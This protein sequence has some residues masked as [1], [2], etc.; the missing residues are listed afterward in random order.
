MSS[1]PEVS[2]QEAEAL[3]NQI[4]N[5][6]DTNNDKSISLH[7]FQSFISKDLDILK[8]LLSYG[9]ISKEDLRPDYGGNTDVPETDSDLENE[10]NKA[11]IDRDERV[12]MIKEG[13]EHVF[14]FQ[15]QYAEFYEK[16][17]VSTKSMQWKKTIL[18]PVFQDKNKCQDQLPQAS[19]EMEFIYGFRCSDTRQNIR[20]N[21][22]NEIVYHNG[23]VG[24]VYDLKGNQ[25][26][27][28]DHTDDI[29]CMD[30]N[31]NLVATG[32]IGL[33]PLLCIW[34]S[35][36]M[37]TKVTFKGVLKNGIGQ[38]A[39]SYDYRRVAA[40]SLEKNKCIVVY[41]VEKAINSKL[42][43]SLKLQEDGLICQTTLYQPVVFDLKFDKTGKG[44]IAACLNE[45]LFMQIEGQQLKIVKGVWSQQNSPQ[46]SLCISFIETSVITGMFKGQLLVWKNSKLS[47]QHP[48]HSGPVMSMY[49]RDQNS[50]IIT[51]GKDGIVIV[52]DN[53]LKKLNRIDLKETKVY[54]SKITAVA[55]D[56]KMENLI[57]GT[58]SSEIIEVLKKTQTKVIMSGHWDGKLYGLTVHPKTQFIYTVGEDNLLAQWDLKKHVL[59]QS[60]KLQFPARCIELCNNQKH[61]AIGC[62][63][64]NVLIVDPKSLVVM[65]SFK[66]NNDSV[67]CLKFSLDCEYL[68]VAYGQ[69]SCEIYAYNCKNTF[70]Q[71]VK[72]K[73]SQ[74]PVTHIDFAKEKKIIQCCNQG[75]QLLFF[76]LV[77]LNSHQKPGKQ[78]REKDYAILKNIKWETNTC[79]YGYDIQGIW[80]PCSNGQDIN[81]VDLSNKY[82][83]LIAGDDFSNVKIFQYPCDFQY[84][85]FIKYSGHS[86]HI[87]KVRFAYEDQYVVSIGGFDKT[88]IQWKYNHEQNK[89]ELPENIEKKNNYNDDKKEN[90]VN[91]KNNI[92]IP[93]QYEGQ[94]SNCVPSAY[95]NID[96]QKLN[97]I[98]CQ[99]IQLSHVFGVR[100]KH[101]NEICKNMIK[102]AVGEKIVYTTAGVCIINDINKQQYFVKHTNDIISLAVHPKGNIAATGS[103]SNKSKT[104]EIYIWEIE[105][106][107]IISQ[108]NDFHIN[109]VSHIEFSPDGTF[110]LT[111]G[112][113]QNYSI[114]IYD[115]Q[116]SRMV[117][118]Q[119]TDIFNVTGISWKNNMEF[120]SC[121]LAH[122][123]F[124]KIQGRNLSFKSGSEIEIFQQQM[125]VTYTITGKCISGSS[126]GCLFLWNENIL[127]NKI[128][129]H[130]KK[131]NCLIS[132]GNESIFSGGD[133]GKIMKWKIESKQNLQDS[134]DIIEL[135]PLTK[136]EFNIISLCT[137][138]KG[139]FCQQEPLEVKFSSLK[140]V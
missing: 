27:Y 34:D 90:L 119:K 120:A 21:L 11:S 83:V 22:N 79:I 3:T 20:Y 113:D 46:A 95:N 26:F 103:S 73:G 60:T 106:K 86:S 12:E 75:Y 131:I 37:E 53:S 1:K 14:S 130:K 32:Q 69:P 19:L 28:L 123:K 84:T 35:K 140:M 4:I 110:L 74:F 56:Y 41:D 59:V 100:T 61:L 10:Q 104:C 137:D 101:N 108:I 89:Y 17:E 24:I 42:N 71:I 43:P 94:I 6:Y 52:W 50:G 38:V 62:I 54:L 45:V 115:W 30:V 31:K 66:D 64:G 36:T 88:I 133:D 47:A 13:I 33:Y 114:A 135:F 51:G 128:N 70:K 80:P 18:N 111:V 129:A 134:S 125:A 102:Y 99:S 136:Y 118:N 63:N 117:A 39:I 124:W 112:Q 85:S 72:L 97:L 105:T 67:S 78:I 91:E 93:K 40:V 87:T 48:A 2:I 23:A 127:Q 81:T 9:L 25:R 132:F 138:P 116:Q 96:I 29:I 8:L 16:Q 121:G 98:P 7:E 57:I 82:N 68:V 107:N 49:T 122:I 126:E 77:E 5:K 58:R 15:E 76:N 44:I 65:F 139:E 92:H 55:E 109:G